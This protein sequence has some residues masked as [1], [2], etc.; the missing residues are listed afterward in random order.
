MKIYCVHYVPNCEEN[1]I[2]YFA[3][4]R[5]TCNQF[6]YKHRNYYGSNYLIIKRYYL[7]HWYRV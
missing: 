4:N 6:I 1:Y 2:I 7:N 3:F 5:F